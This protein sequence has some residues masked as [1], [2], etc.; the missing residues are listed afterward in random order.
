MLSATMMKTSV[1]SLEGELTLDTIDAAEARVRPILAE[2]EPLLVLD[3]SSVS[4]VTTPGIG[5]LL[6]LHRAAKAKGGKVVFACL[7]PQVSDVI[8]RTQLERVLL[9]AGTLAEA[10]SMTASD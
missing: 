6:T 10:D 8:R 2:D 1:M 3:L 5:L 7:S 4:K 9:L